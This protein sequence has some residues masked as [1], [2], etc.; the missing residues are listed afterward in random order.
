MFGQSDIHPA[1]PQPQR[2]RFYQ[3]LPHP[4]LDELRL[5]AYLCDKLF[6]GAVQYAF[7]GSF[8]A[9]IRQY[10]PVTA[11]DLEIVLEHGGYDQT[12]QIMSDHPESFGITQYNDHIV[13][14]REDGTF[15]YG[16]SLQRF[17]LGNEGYPDSFV[18]PYNSDLRDPNVHHD[19]EPNYYQRTLGF[20][21][22]RKIPILRSRPL[23]YQRLWCFDRRQFTQY[24]RSD[25]RHLRGDIL[26]IRSFVHLAI[27]DQ[28]Q[29]FPV[30]E[31]RVITQV[32]RSWMLFAEDNFV[33]STMEDVNAWIQLGM[34]LNIYDVA[35]RFRGN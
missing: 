6:A 9:L 25:E 11:C 3:L 19:L 4:S 23:L 34:E 14:I 15:S 16:V 8:A 30:G 13:V 20:L 27:A 1:R 28:D 24:G 7:G 31:R 32:V 22:D 35:E 10:R 5:A 2:V 21:N 29:P 12:S 18:P 17:E 33:E 26:D